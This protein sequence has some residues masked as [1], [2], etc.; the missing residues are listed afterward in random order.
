[1][2]TDLAGLFLYAVISGLF[3]FTAGIIARSTL[4]S[5]IGLLIIVGLVGI[6]VSFANKEFHWVERSSVSR[7]SYRPVA[8]PRDTVIVP[9]REIIHHYPSRPERVYHEPEY[10]YPVEY[11]DEEPEMIPRKRKD[12]FAD[13]DIC[14]NHGFLN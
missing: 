12:P 7:S 8:V 1:M 6:L 13:L 5:V 10:E 11:E 9:A 14:D 3:F 2:K 4:V